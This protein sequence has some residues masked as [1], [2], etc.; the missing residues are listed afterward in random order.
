MTVHPNRVCPS[1]NGT[2]KSGS[3]W[4]SKGQVLPATTIGNRSEI[5]DLRAKIA[6]LEARVKALEDEKRGSEQ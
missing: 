2:G 6:E 3:A 1:C 5:E 4:K